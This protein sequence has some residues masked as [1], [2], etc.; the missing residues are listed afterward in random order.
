MR[1]DARP[2]DDFYEFAN[3]AWLDH[4]E[5]PA[6]RSSY[7]SF[8]MIVEQAEKDTRAIIEGAAA[9]PDAQGAARH[10][11]PLYPRQAQT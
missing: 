1:R 7:S 3:G 6:D 4:T 8:T 5:I 10:R 9:N 2:G 11:R